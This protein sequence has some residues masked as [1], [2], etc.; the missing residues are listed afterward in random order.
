MKKLLLLLF[1]LLISFNS[2][3]KWIKIGDVFDGVTSVTVYIDT[4][5]KHGEY[6]YFWQMLDYSKPNGQSG[7]MSVKS[8][9]QG[10]CGVNRVKKLSFIFY[11][12]SMGLGTPKA[13][14]PS[15]PKWEYPV[16]KSTGGATLRF[17]CTYADL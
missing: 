16:P 4:I 17:A 1:S 3:G 9:W 7:T 15:D 12:L 8:Y 6:V 14:D 11:K 2:Y 5:K 13:H 10:D